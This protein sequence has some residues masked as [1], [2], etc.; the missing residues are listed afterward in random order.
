MHG[1]RVRQHATVPISAFLL[2]APLL[3]KKKLLP[4]CLTVVSGFQQKINKLSCCEQSAP[5]SGR[6]E[7]C[8]SHHVVYRLPGVEAA[9][10]GN[11]KSMRGAYVHEAD[12]S[13][14]FRGTKDLL[15]GPKG[16]RASV[17]AA[18]ATRWVGGLDRMRAQTARIC[19][20][21][22]LGKD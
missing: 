15:S 10:D 19:R 5:T 18:A 22:S 7:H 17:D 8:S 1:G 2:P 14:F 3:T 6:R 4:K 9:V 16:Q 11:S 20:S 12:E 21:K 13:G